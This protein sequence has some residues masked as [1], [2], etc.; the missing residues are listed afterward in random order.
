[1][2][3]LDR[4]QYN[5]ATDLLGKGFASRVYKCFDKLL[6]KEVALKLSKAIQNRQDDS[7]SEKRIIHENIIRHIDRVII[8]KEDA[9]GESEKIEVV[10]MELATTTAKAYYASHQES[11]LLYNIL[12]STLEVLHFLHQQQIT[13]NNIKPANILISIV[14]DKPVVKITGMAPTAD[15]HIL[16]FNFSTPLPDDLF[17]LTP[18]Q[19]RREDQLKE[20]AFAA[21]IWRF[22]VSAYEIITGK[23]LFKSDSLEQLRQKINQPLQ[24][25]DMVAL[26]TAYHTLITACLTTGSEAPSI[27]TLREMLTATLPPLVEKEEI[28]TDD[29]IILNAIKADNEENDTTILLQPK[30]NTDDTSVLNTIRTAARQPSGDET[31]VFSK[32]PATAVSPVIEESNT[33]GK[34]TLF[35]RYEYSPVSN[36]IGKGGFSR[37]Y[38][39]YDRKLNRWVALKVYKSNELSE[40]YS[41]FAEIQR[42]IN[43]DH[44]N[45]CRYLD[46]E[47]MVNQNAFGEKET[48]QVCVMELMDG[49]NIAEY[50]Q[51]N[52]DEKILNKLISDI[53]RGLSYLHKNGIIHRDIKPANILIK[54]TI[55]GPVAKITDFGISKATDSVNSNSSSTLIVSIPFM[56]PEQFNVKKFG[57]NNRISYNLDLWSLG[58]SVYE[59]FTGKVLFKENENDNSEQ[60]MVN[61]MS[62]TIP[63]KIN[64]LP[65]RLK[66]LVAHCLVKDATTR[67]QQADDL[68]A[69]LTQTTTSHEVAPAKKEA[70]TK[71]VIKETVVIAQPSIEK[72]EIIQKIATPTE[73]PTL[74]PVAEDLSQTKKVS[75]ALEETTLAPPAKKTPKPPITLSAKAK[76][77]TLLV[78]AGLLLLMLLFT[79]FS[80]FMKRADVNSMPVLNNATEDSLILPAVLITDTFAIPVTDTTIATNSVSETNLKKLPAKPRKNVEKLDPNAHHL[81]IATSQKYSIKISG[82]KHLSAVTDSGQVVRFPITPGQYI[83]EATPEH[84]RKYERI[85]V[86]KQIDLGKSYK[87]DLP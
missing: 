16:D 72:Q 77:R 69:M 43:L 87:L 14:D 81:M 49:G 51:K 22:G 65:P 42:V 25:A 21:D 9:F 53:L 7:E 23:V 41:P 73:S 40:R 74:Q 55:E 35:N 84:G 48:T 33:E 39:A 68:L 20:S 2:L 10:A 38:K 54:E 27:E 3:Y 29:T 46:I 17:Y 18:Y 15:T 70:I 50:Y 75:F 57:I 4:Y 62:P 44:A 31:V 5:P 28:Q 37:V 56:A 71:E 30:L 67:V 61:I 82:N 78:A 58:V 11:D 13:H 32:A 66:E 6:N 45:I 19:M 8:E 64:I 80:R 34:V 1:M 83:I 47:E 76:K 26:P 24:P 63:D 79:V 85:Y 60:I 12:D 52:K 86:V 36:L 59:I